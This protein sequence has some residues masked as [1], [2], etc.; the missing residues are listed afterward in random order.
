[1]IYYKALS[2]GLSMF[3]FTLIGG[4]TFGSII[5]E[6]GHAIVGMAVGFRI[7]SWSIAGVVFASYMPNGPA[8]LL[9]LLAGGSAEALSAS[10]AFLFVRYLARYVFRKNEIIKVRSI[11]AGMNRGLSNFQLQFLPFILF[12]I[13]VAFLSFIFHG[14]VAGIWEGLF[15]SSYVAF[16]GEPVLEVFAVA[17][18]LWMAFEILYSRQNKYLKSLAFVD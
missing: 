17:V 16:S 8:K 3:I 1:M 7:K 18:F 6:A 12:G 2:A 13:E 10:S 11:D 15:N 4:F 5:H 9:T 14:V